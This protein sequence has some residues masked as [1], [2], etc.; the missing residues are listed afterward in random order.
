MNIKIRRNIERRDL[1]FYIIGYIIIGII[2]FI[3]IAL[4]ISLIVY[5]GDG[6]QKALEECVNKG[7]D[8][9]YCKSLLN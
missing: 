2:F 9:S 8:I 5:L 6:Y 7:Y 3:L 1:K 4:V